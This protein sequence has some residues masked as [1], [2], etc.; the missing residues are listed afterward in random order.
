MMQLYTTTKSSLT[1]NTTSLIQSK[2]TKMIKKKVCQD[3]C[4]FK[5]EMLLFKSIYKVE[6]VNITLIKCSTQAREFK[7]RVKLHKTTYQEGQ[8]CVASPM[9]Q[10]A[11]T[12]PSK[13]DQFK[14]DKG[15]W[16]KRQAHQTKT[17]I[18]HLV[19]KP[20]RQDKQ[21]WAA[22]WI[23]AWV[24]LLVQTTSH[25]KPSNKS[26]K[27]LPS[28]LG[29]RTPDPRVTNEMQA[30]S[31]SERNSRCTSRSL[32]TS[33]LTREIASILV[34]TTT[35]ICRE[36]FQCQN[37]VRY[38]LQVETMISITFNNDTTSIPKFTQ[39]WVC[40]SHQANSHQQLPQR[41]RTQGSKA[42]ELAIK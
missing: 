18:T 3:R 2:Y 11:T 24:W 37:A 36:T 29:C 16:V 42:L 7:L 38:H 40:P 19:N 12:S 4:K 21:L 34:L 15:L 31:R 8:E 17:T 33:S 20:K 5:G 26:W 27:V 13:N 28:H 22:F 10:P 32:R 39:A 41:V 6:L 14:A 30:W 35:S 1:N 9:A 25:Q 23:Q